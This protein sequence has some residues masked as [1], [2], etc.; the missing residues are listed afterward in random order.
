MSEPI[1]YS[2][3]ERIGTAD[4]CHWLEVRSGVV[5]T[6]WEHASELVRLFNERHAAKHREVRIRRLSTERP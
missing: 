4:D 1:S 2:I 3:I 6:S 5:V